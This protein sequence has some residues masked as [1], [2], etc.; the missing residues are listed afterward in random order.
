MKAKKNLVPSSNIGIASLLVIFLIL[1]LV[2]FA[3][4]SLSTA[5]NDYNHSVNLAEHKTAYYEASNTSEKIVSIIAKEGSDKAAIN[6]E[7]ESEGIDVDV[8]VSGGV[9]TWSVP[10]SDTQSLSVE[11]GCSDLKIKKWKV[12]A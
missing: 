4:L 1:C 5:R 11:L 8:S 7:L 2:V 6:D 12:E 3:A 9:A 10:V